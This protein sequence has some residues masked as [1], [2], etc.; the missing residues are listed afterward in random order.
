MAVI[1]KK[2]FSN[3]NQGILGISCEIALKWMPQ[4]LTDNL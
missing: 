3:S 2:Q 1:L 4:D